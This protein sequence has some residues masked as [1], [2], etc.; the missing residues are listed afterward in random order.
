MTSNNGPY[1]MDKNESPGSACNL[2]VKLKNIL[3]HCV[4]A[5]GV[6]KTM[7]KKWY[8][9]FINF[10]NSHIPFPWERCQCLSGANNH[11]GATWSAFLL[12]VSR[13][14]KKYYSCL[15]FRSSGKFL[16]LDI[17][18]VESTEKRVSCEAAHIS[19][20][21]LVLYI[22]IPFGHCCMN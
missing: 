16:L 20:I 21:Y 1:C 22:M 10:K 18:L 19:T 2:L 13:K 17:G 6:L 15:K 5:K 14:R 4:F 3:P 7:Q 11:S 12:S 8:C 9:I